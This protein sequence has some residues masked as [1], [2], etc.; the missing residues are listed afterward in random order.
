MK[1]ISSC[2]NNLVQSK[3]KSNNNFA[4]LH[5]LWCTKGRIEMTDCRAQ[6][7]M[8]PWRSSP[9]CLWWIGTNNWHCSMIGQ[10]CCPI[11]RPSVH[12]MVRPLESKWT[13]CLYLSKDCLWWHS[14]LNWAVISSEKN[15][16]LQRD[17]SISML[18]SSVIIWLQGSRRS[19]TYPVLR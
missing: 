8:P 17:A 10:S 9:L 5:Q 11:L 2:F 19:F 13:V 1:F 14:I 16:W 7:Q 15:W 3:Q 12:P 6:W 18:W 4:Y